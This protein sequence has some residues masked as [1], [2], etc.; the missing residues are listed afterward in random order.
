MRLNHLTLRAASCSLLML[1]ILPYTISQIQLLN[2][3]FSNS[4]TLTAN[5]LNINDVEQW[6]AEQLEVFDINSTTA[7]RL[8]M[9]PWTSSWFQDYKG[10]LLFKLIEGDFVFTTQV[11]ATNRAGNAMPG[12]LYS[13]AG[14]MIRAPRDY[15]NGAYG[16]GGWTSGGENFVFLAAGFAATSH[17]SCSGCPGPHLEVK[18]TVNGS[19]SLQV[20]SIAT[21]ENVNIRI[22]R[23]GGAIIVLYQLPGEAWEVRERYDR[24]D[25][26]EEVQIGFVTYTDWQKVSTYAPFF[27]NSNVLND[28][29]NPDPSSNQNLAFNPDLI[30]EFEFGRFDDTSNPF[31]GLDLVNQATDAE[32]LSFLGYDTEVFCPTE[33]EVLDTITDGQIAEV[34]TSDFI[35]ADNLIQ[36]NST[37]NYSSLNSVELIAGFECEG[38]AEFTVDLN[39]CN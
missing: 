4:N 26:P 22:A 16:T 2:D 17:P 11:S 20:S 29:L 24:S 14:L 12:G 27:H 33:L 15:P 3:E 13:L 32:L 10:T 28:N 18:N 9:M 25:F 1:F 31:P 6:D 38:G 7:D 35:I 39:G 34:S 37:V 36:S 8:H 21:Y 5:W 23:V 19:S 30:G